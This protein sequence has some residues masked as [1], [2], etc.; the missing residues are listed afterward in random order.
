MSTEGTVEV[1]G[2]TT[3]TEE[4]PRT[5]DSA[6]VDKGTVAEGDVGTVLND[7]DTPEEVTRAVDTVSVDDDDDVISA[8]LDV[9]APKDVARTVD[10]AVDVEDCAGTAL[11]ERLSAFIMS[12]AFASASD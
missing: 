4:L 10:K 2:G 9:A 5:V 3:D 1:V 12:A 6:I 7:A 11:E 8:L